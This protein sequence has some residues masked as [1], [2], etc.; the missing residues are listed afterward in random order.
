MSRRRIRK[1]PEDESHRAV[2]ESKQHVEDAKNRN[3]EVYQVAGRLKRQR[4]EN[5][6]ADKLI[7]IMSG[8]PGRGLL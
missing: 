6:F 1:T 2:A 8:H 3:P 7:Q 5:H 4:E